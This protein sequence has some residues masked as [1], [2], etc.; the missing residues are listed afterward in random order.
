MGAVA[1]D[2][3]AGRA[4]TQA[5]RTGIAAGAWAAERVGAQSSFGTRADLE[6]R[7]RR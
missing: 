6:S 2:L 4:L 7:A 5:A 1:A 3:A